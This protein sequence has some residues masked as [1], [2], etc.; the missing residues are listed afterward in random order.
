MIKDRFIAGYITSLKDRID[1]AK[2]ALALGVHKDL[3]EV[4]K[5][6]GSIL[7]LQDA[8]RTLEACIE[9]QDV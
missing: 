4:G 8:L 2:D 9:E 5:L 6:Q 7:G 3:Y 1:D